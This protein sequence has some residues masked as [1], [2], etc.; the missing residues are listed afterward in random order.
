MD[1]TVYLM[2]MGGLLLVCLAILVVI[3]GRSSSRGKPPMSD[4]LPTTP[5]ASSRVMIA[6][7]EEGGPFVWVVGGRPHASLEEISDPDQRARADGFLAELRAWLGMAVEGNAPALASVTRVPG[8]TPRPSAPDDEMRRPLFDRLRASFIEEGA[9]KS[10]VP[11]VPATPIVPSKKLE[12]LEVL[13]QEELRRREVAPSAHVRT[14][15]TG[16]IEILVGERRYESVNDVPD[17]IVR[18]ALRDA[19]KRW[20]DEGLRND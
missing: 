1:F 13:F 2:M 15:P 10:V 12:Q 9:T 16:L 3:L 14:G 4:V 11:L 17:D 19:V 20:E 18:A 7:A 8:G 5:V 6:Q